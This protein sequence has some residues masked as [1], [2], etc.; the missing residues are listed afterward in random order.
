MSF[1]NI[2]AGN[3]CKGFTVNSIVHNDARCSDGTAT[4]VKYMWKEQCKMNIDSAKRKL[5]RFH[6]WRIYGYTMRDGKGLRRAAGVTLQ[7]PS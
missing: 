7:C 6:I 2:S 1:A 4:R 5:G 3:K